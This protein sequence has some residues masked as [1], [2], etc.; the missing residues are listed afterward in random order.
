MNQKSIL[1]T[2]AT[3][4]LGSHLLRTLILSENKVYVLVRSAKNKTATQRIIE[5]LKF[6]DDNIPDNYLKNISVIEGDITNNN[7][8]LKETKTIDE[9]CNET[10]II[11]HSAA[12]TDLMTP[13][14]IIRKYNVEGT[15]NILK[16][17]LK[18]K[19]IRKLCH[20]STSYVVGKKDGIVFD[21]NMLDV[22]QE[23]NNTYEQTKFEAEVL[24]H[25]YM[26]K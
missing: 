22:G 12:M 21:E 25:E 16:L 13:L 10:E 11:I 15:K 3:G 18:C 26:K 5:S 2:G 9:L 24:C 8:G 20:I 19:N 17:A 1:L 23:F 7:L 4:F 14:E 6:W